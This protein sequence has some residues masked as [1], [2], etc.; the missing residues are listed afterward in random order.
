MPNEWPL[1]IVVNDKVKWEKDGEKYYP[2]MWFGSSDEIVEEWTLGNDGMTSIVSAEDGLGSYGGQMNINGF[3]INYG[4]LFGDNCFWYFGACR[5]EGA[6]FHKV[7]ETCPI[8]LLSI[9][10]NKNGDD[11]IE[12]YCIDFQRK[13]QK[14]TEDV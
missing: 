7:I 11:V 2:I 14:T 8:D 3:E 5:N 10:S 9:Y 4:D 6:D 13:Q 12:K 1:P